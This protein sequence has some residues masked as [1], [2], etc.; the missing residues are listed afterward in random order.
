M[1]IQPMVLDDRYLGLTVPGQLVYDKDK[2]DY[3]EAFFLQDMFGP[4]ETVFVVKCVGTAK[5]VIERDPI[6]NPNYQDRR[7]QES[8]IAYR[9][10]ATGDNNSN[11]VLVRSY[12]T[13]DKRFADDVKLFNGFRWL[14]KRLWFTNFTTRV[15]TYGVLNANKFQLAATNVNIAVNPFEQLGTYGVTKETWK[16]NH[17]GLP[18]LTAPDVEYEDT[19]YAT[20]VYARD[21]VSP[22]TLS[23]FYQV[24]QPQPV[25]FKWGLFYQYGS[26]DGFG[27]KMAMLGIP[28]KTFIDIPLHLNLDKNHVLSSPIHYSFRENKRIVLTEGTKTLYGLA[29]NKA[30]EDFY[31]G[32]PTPF[33]KVT[34]RL[35]SRKGLS[36]LETEQLPSRFH[37]GFYNPSFIYTAL[38]NFAA[39]EGN[40][41]IVY[42]L[43]VQE[44]V[45]E[46]DSDDTPLNFAL[47]N[48]VANENA[49]VFLSIDKPII[50]RLRVS[51]RVLEGIRFNLVHVEGKDAKILIQTNNVPLKLIVEVVDNPS[52]SVSG[53][54][55]LV[56]AFTAPDPDRSLE[57]FY[58]G[59][60]WQIEKSTVS[61]QTDISRLVTKRF[62]MDNNT[63]G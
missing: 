63:K 9:V 58:N 23:Y 35:L 16:C 34:S 15:E 33:T 43:N 19:S 51:Q 49:K 17:L 56:D 12:R 20:S 18:Y 10:V 4:D 38:F 5:I 39:T 37:E 59:S 41:Y 14:Q 6:A 2:G 52:V 29:S 11:Y 48:V 1:F 8:S 42:N 57:V 40:L 26:L 36:R 44:F 46:A 55:C 28:F 25:N 21:K 7:R 32:D 13:S 24:Q 45:L 60:D 22:L 27:E 30:I 61:P 31:F 53:E 3:V 54:I 47:F 50:V 62:R